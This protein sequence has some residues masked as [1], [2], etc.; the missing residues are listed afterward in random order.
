MDSAEKDNILDLSDVIGSEGM[1]FGAMAQWRK[2]VRPGMVAHAFKDA[3]APM[4]MSAMR[5]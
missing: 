5:H 3:V 4:L 2:S 1:M